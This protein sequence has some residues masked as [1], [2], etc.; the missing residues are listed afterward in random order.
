MRAHDRADA[1]RV[2]LA[3]RMKEA[4]RSPTCASACA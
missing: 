2:G 1:D 3:Q 4:I